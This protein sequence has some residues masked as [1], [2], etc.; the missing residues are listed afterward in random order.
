MATSEPAKSPRPAQPNPPPPA[1]S[2][3]T[4]GSSEARA[5]QTKAKALQVFLCHSRADKPAVRKLYGRLKSDGYKPWLDAV[6]LVPGQDWELEIGKAVRAS[7]TVIVCLSAQSVTKAGFMQK[8][9]KYA[10]DVADEQPEGR[11]YI[12][13]AR[14][15]ECDVPAR[16]SKFHWVDL[17]EDDGYYKLLE[18]LKMRVAEI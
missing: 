11:I 10:L 16:L 14:L 12:I 7:D 13:P 5:V 18:A 2:R 8:E 6:N 1:P 15:E 3:T 4:G 17:F 9:I